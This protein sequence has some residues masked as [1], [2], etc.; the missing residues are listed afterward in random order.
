MKIE[1]PLMNAKPAAISINGMTLQKSSPVTILL[2]QVTDD[3]KALEKA[4]EIRI[5]VRGNKAMLVKL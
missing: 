5:I 2:S 4:G 3:L 1:H